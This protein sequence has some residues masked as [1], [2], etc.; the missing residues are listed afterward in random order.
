M[1]GIVFNQLQ[2]FVTKNHGISTWK[3]LLRSA[4]LS[5]KMYMPTE[6]YPDQDIQAIVKTA[7]EQ[8]NVPA[9]DILEDFGFYISEGMLRIYAS[10]IKAEWKSLDLIEH[11]ENTMHKAVRHADK[12][13]MPPALTCQRIAHNKVQILYNSER[14]MIEL[15]IGIIK[16]IGRY[17]NEKLLVSRSSTTGGDTLLEVTKIG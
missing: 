7:S 1:H 2:Q 12:N 5:H 4:G 10:S 6:I 16:G 14:Q 11:T 8:L 17:Y 13:A 9:A 3:N 15:G